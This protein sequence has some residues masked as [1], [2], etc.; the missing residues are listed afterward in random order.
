M[1]DKVKC[2]NKNCIG[3][4]CEGCEN[5]SND[6]V[7]E[8]A[9]KPQ[10]K[11]RKGQIVIIKS[12]NKQLPFRILEVMWQDGWN[13]KFNARNYVSEFMIRELTPDEAG[14]VQVKPDLNKPIF[15]IETENTWVELV[16]QCKTGSYSSINIAS[17]KRRDAIL[18]VDRIIVDIKQYLASLAQSVNYL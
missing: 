12:T 17:Q 1:D 3:D 11:F 14:Y 5:M 10:A 16:A 2:N 8:L 6:K 13:Y 15:D 9:G 4:V 7:T 18:K